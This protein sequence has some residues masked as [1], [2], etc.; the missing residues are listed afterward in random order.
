[1]KRRVILHIG[2]EKS[3]STTLQAA[4]WENRESLL[5]LGFCFPQSLGQSNH[6]GLAAYASSLPRTEAL[7]R[8]FRGADGETDVRKRIAGLLREE[9]NALPSG[10]HTVVLSGEHC[11][12]HLTELADVER[13]RDLLAEHFEDC[14]V[15]VYLRRQV[16]LAASLYSQQIKAGGT[17]TSVLP[18]AGP[19]NPYFNYA[20]LLKRWG[21]VFGRV[22]IRPRIYSR[23]EFKDGDIVRAGSL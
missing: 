20:D 15:T 16:D 2:T 4:L 3:G 22:N 13:L 9:M 10:V 1:M 19:E 7:R 18:K 6:T 14:V 12:S 23:A 17:Q 21:A 5:K 8:S 11:H